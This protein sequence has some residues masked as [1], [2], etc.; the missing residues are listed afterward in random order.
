MPLM[1]LG[2]ALER[3]RQCETAARY[4]LGNLSQNHLRTFGTRS[5]VRPGG[6]GE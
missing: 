5:G 2:C 6:L 3:P 1:Y 4:K